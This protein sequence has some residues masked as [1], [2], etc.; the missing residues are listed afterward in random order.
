MFGE[1]SYHFISIIWQHFL[2]HVTS[3]DESMMMIY[4]NYYGRRSTLGINNEAS[5]PPRNARL[6]VSLRI[7]PGGGVVR[8]SGVD[9]SST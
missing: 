7:A 3:L 6:A 8:N 4:K 9:F 5:T 1:L 2:C